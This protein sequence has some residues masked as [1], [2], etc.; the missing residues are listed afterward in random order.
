MFFGAFPIFSEKDAH[1]NTS[2]RLLLEIDLKT[3][4]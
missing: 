4:P 2:S 1:Q 3:G